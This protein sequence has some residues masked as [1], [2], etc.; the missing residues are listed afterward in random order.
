[1]T[2]ILKTK[3]KVEKP[4]KKEE[5]LH[6]GLE[7]SFSDKDGV[8]V[9]LGEF[10][11]S[12]DWW[13]LKRGKNRATIVLHD[14]VKKI[15]DRAGISTDVEY[16]VLIA[17]SVMNNYTT[18]MECRIT[19]PVGKVTTE[20][21]E[22]NR[23]NLGNRGRSNPINMCQKRAYDRAVFRH[24]G[25]TGFLGEEELPDEEES[26]NEMDNLSIE[27]QKAIVPFINK[28]VN[29]KTPVELKTIS[30]EIKR[31]S[32]ALMENQLAVLRSLWKKQ[33]SSLQK[34]TF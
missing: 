33:L 9:K 17:P 5:V 14:A 12:S 15:A 32:S 6:P 19:G 13:E 4:K 25:I 24:L 8:A 2:K 3:T 21:G 11:S 26:K 29:S 31:D 20:L 10:L 16:K 27:E 1:M 34:I 18:A 30:V 23:G 28:I 7:Q 22:V